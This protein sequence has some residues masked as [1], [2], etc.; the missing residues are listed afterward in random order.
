MLFLRR[1]LTLFLLVLV[2]TCGTAVQKNQA[3]D[4]AMIKSYMP[5]TWRGEDFLFPVGPEGG[6]IVVT[7]SD[8]NNT[9][10]LYAGTWGSGMYKSVNGGI[11]W[12]TINIGLNY[13]YINSLAIDPQ[14]PSILYA[15]TYEYGVYKTTNAGL[16]W[17]PTG[18]G[19]SQYPI[20]Y[21]IAIDPV[22]P[23]VVYVGT[24]N[25]QPGPPWGGGLYKTWNGG[26]TWVKSKLGITE[27]WVYD[28]AI[29]PV[30]H[31]TLYAATHSKGVFK[32]TNG[33]AYWKAINTGITDYSTRSIVIDHTNPDILYVGT[34][35]YGGVFKSMNGGTS[36]KPSSNGLYHKIYALTMDPINPNIIY[37]AT[38]RKG[39]M[40]TKTAGASWHNTGL[41]PDMIYIVMID[42]HN[43]STLF[44]GTMGDGFFI[45]Y[46]RGDNWVRS[47]TGFRVTNITAIAVD[48]STVITDTMTVSNTV[49][50]ADPLTA[51]QVMTQT[52]ADAVYTSIYGAGIYKS[53]D[54]GSTWRS[55]NY[56]LSEKWVHSMAMSRV[57]PLTLYAGTDATGFYITHDGG[58]T[59][60]ASNN[61]LLESAV[62]EITFD[63]WVDP[64]L[65]SDLFDQ[66][67][68]EGVPDSS[69][70]VSGVVSILAIGVDS[71]DPQKLYIGTEGGGIYRSNNGG[72]RWYLT[73]LTT[74]TVYTILSDPFTIS[75]LYAGC[76]SASNTMFRSLDGGVTWKLSNV[77]MAGLT[78]Y[79]LAANPTL[80]GVLYAG[81][82]QG[83]YKSIDGAKTWERFSLL[84]Q[85]VLSLGLSPSTPGTMIAGT[86]V[87]L[88]ISEDNGITW[89]TLDY[90]LVNKEI[91]SLNMDPAESHSINLI[92]TRG[93]GIYLHGFEIVDWK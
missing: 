15:G 17:S 36:W 75:V 4:N 19:L 53:T 29:D 27:E 37:A 76:D 12:H 57:D 39:I 69:D 83:V 34:W 2:I 16:T 41:S 8:P 54:L 93:G 26:D 72:I 49:E 45:S 6:S 22:T 73:D 18:P 43:T 9:N 13:L 30:H 11:S 20:V 81:T 58:R 66:A 52:V 42:P 79:T 77:G 33:G 71:F 87:G 82:S 61:G 35:H 65:R 25:Q 67:F 5:F 89:E 84:G 60:V 62:V 24:R 85:T 32:S 21:T 51:A 50:G 88:Y 46:D 90:G 40:V 68:F 64:S 48:W 55:I 78:V 80:P 7:V 63:A 47:N 3:A 38:Y 59:W 28:I 10:I 44:A 1:Y 23:N 74:Q 56:G 91:T 70:A 86:P 31:E 14:N 92:G